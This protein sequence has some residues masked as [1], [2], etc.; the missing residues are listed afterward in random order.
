MTFSVW[1]LIPMSN[2]SASGA[3]K[4]VNSGSLD[5][6]LSILEI[7]TKL[8]YVKFILSIKLAVLAVILRKYWILILVSCVM[9]IVKLNILLGNG[10]FYVMKYAQNGSHILLLSVVTD[11][12]ITF[13]ESS[14]HVS[15]LCYII[16]NHYHIYYYIC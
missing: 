5:T 15:T 14:N 8:S 12:Y 4:K 7:F 13:N 11:F 1:I 9:P 16:I 3:R 6:Q 10:N 2:F